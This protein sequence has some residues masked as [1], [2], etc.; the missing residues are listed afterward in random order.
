MQTG[1]RA[2]PPPQAPRG[3][4]PAPKESLRRARAS[5]RPQGTVIAWKVPVLVGASSRIS[6]GVPRSGRR[7]P[8]LAP[9]V[10]QDPEGDRLGSRRG[11]ERWGAFHQRPKRGAWSTRSIPASGPELRLAPWWRRCDRRPTGWDRRRGLPCPGLTVAGAAPSGPAP[12]PAPKPE[13]PQTF[14]PSDSATCHPADRR[15]Y[16]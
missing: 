6:A 3:D 5:A 10:N 1:R 7:G 14:A 4:G 15:I 9:E 8:V 2:R 13:P 12:R 11:S 16:P